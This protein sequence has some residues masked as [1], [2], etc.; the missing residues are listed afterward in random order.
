MLL[1]QGDHCLAG[2]DVGKEVEGES[3]LP[4]FCCELLKSLRDEEAHVGHQDIDA[5]AESG[6]R[7][8]DTGFD[9]LFCTQVCYGGTHADGV[10]ST[11]FIRQASKRFL[12]DIEQ[13]EV[14][15]SPGE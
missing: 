9:S 5:A 14:G 11:Q 3:A 13:R 2:V 1:H 6:K 15:A 10:R 12:V 4:L 8:C 7:L